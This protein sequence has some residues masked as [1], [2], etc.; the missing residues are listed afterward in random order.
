MQILPRSLCLLSKHFI[1]LL[2]LKTNI[3]NISNF[4]MYKW[5]NCKIGIFRNTF[6]LESE[7]EKLEMIFQKWKLWVGY[8][9]HSPLNSQISSVN[10][11]LLPMTLVDYGPTFLTPYV[12]RAEA[13]DFECPPKRNQWHDEEC[14]SSSAALQTYAYKR[15]LTN[16]CWRLQTYAAV[17]RNV[18]HCRGLQAEQKG[19]QEGAQEEIAGKSWA[20]G[21]RDVQ[22]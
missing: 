7:W 1:I 19:T 12:L 2:F 3:S 20:W 18:C 16:S 6:E 11:N 10:H 4:I 9:I 5:D 15:T 8:I 14:R 22:E 13:E 17:C 21:N